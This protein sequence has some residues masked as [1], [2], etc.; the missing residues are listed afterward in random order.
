MHLYFLHE[1]VLLHRHY[2]HEEICLRWRYR[3]GYLRHWIQVVQHYSPGGIQRWRIHVHQML[4][5]H[6]DTCLSMGLV[7]QKFRLC[8]LMVKINIKKY[9]TIVYCYFSFTMVSFIWILGSVIPRLPPKPLRPPT[10]MFNFNAPPG[11]S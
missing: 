9:F 6:E 7:L 10:T 5:I 4:F 2:R 8:N 11:S 3:L 1:M